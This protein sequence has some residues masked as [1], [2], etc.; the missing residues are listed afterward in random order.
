LPTVRYGDG[1][2]TPFQQALLAVEIAV[3]ALHDVARESPMAERT[4][5]DALAQIA[6]F[7]FDIRSSDDRRAEQAKPHAP[8]PRRL[9]QQSLFR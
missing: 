9:V 3:D 7:G 1:P 2:M 8:A 6:Y 4:A 5:R